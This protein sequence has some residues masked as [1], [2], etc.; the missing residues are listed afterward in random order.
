MSKEN[1][2]LLVAKKELHRFFCDRRMV[3]SALIFP[4]ILYYIVFA[5]FAPFMINIA[6]ESIR[7]GTVYAINPPPVIQKVFE[8]TGINFALANEDEK[9]K[10]LDG[11]AQKNGNFLIGNL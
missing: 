3:I 4:G 8:H 7:D 5:F 10:I 9:E 1:K 11:I 6:M 2:F